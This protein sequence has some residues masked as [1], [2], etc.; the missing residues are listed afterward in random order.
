[1]NA[2]STVPDDTLRPA[3]ATLTVIDPQHLAANLT[4]GPDGLW[5]P[6]S[7]SRVD[8]PDEGNAFCFQVED[9]SFWFAHRNRCL[10]GAIARFPPPGAIFDIGGGNG[11]VARGLVDAGYEAVV[12]EPGAVGAS[13]ARARGLAPVICSTLEDAGFLAGAL[14]A[15]GLFDVLEHIEDDRHV[16]GR[17]A[18][19]IQPGGR[20]YLT[21]PA[22]QALWSGED[23]LGGHHRRYTRASLSRVVTEAGFTV[24]FASYFFWPLPLPILLLRALPWRLGRRPPADIEAIRRELKPPSGPA[25]KALMALLGLEHRWLQRGGTLPVGG[26][27]LLVARRG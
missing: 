6:R 2:G 22:Y 16:L 24:E 18:A 26:S 23:E 14:P 17:L 8:Y 7:R 27:C 19:L 4:L 1:M 12:V 9:Q 21:V 11:F 20:L 3:H 5:W 15:A 25:V 13:N 10:L